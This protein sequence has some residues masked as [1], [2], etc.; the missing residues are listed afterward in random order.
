V[1]R[2]R[3]SRSVRDRKLVHVDARVL[4]DQLAEGSRR[5]VELYD[6]LHTL[7]DRRTE[8]IA[9]AD[10]SRG[11]SEY[12]RMRAQLEA[13]EPEVQKLADRIRTELANLKKVRLPRSSRSMETRGEAIEDPSKR[14][15][16]EILDLSNRLLKIADAQQAAVRAWNAEPVPSVRSEFEATMARLHEEFS[17]ILAQKLALLEAKKIL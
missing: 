12:E 11:P 8:I 4:P 5:L 13:L 10:L 16:V 3:K 15:D 6:E 17:A 2:R 14:L 9:G 1:N 7:Q